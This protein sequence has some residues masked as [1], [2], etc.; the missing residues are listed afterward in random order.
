MITERGRALLD[1]AAMFTA[2][3]LFWGVLLGAWVLGPIE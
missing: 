3:L 1:W 2:C